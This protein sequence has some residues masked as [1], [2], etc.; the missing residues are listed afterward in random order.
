MLTRWSTISFSRR[1]IL[2]GVMFKAGLH[3][4]FIHHNSLSTE[5]RG[6]TYSQGVTLAP[7]RNME[8]FILEHGTSSLPDRY[9]KYMWQDIISAGSAW[10]IFLRV[11]EYMYKYGAE[12]N[13]W[14]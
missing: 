4:E 10:S 5:A 9:M 13:L 7:H 12:A 1:T 2:L 3:D 11:K 8:E 14:C 6:S